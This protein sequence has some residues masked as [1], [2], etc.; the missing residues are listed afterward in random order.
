M[1]V[2]E[3]HWS[4]KALPQKALHALINHKPGECL[5]Y[6]LVVGNGHLVNVIRSPLVVSQSFGFTYGNDFSNPELREQLTKF[7]GTEAQAE[8]C[9]FSQRRTVM[10]RVPAFRSSTRRRRRTRSRRSSANSSTC[11]SLEIKAPQNNPSMFHFSAK[12]HE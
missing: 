2:S 10:I 6:E 3:Y 1:A 8:R 12:P 7:R 9:H 11:E 4:E 5:V